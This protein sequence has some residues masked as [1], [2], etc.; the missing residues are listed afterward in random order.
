MEKLTDEEMEAKILTRIDREKPLN[1]TELKFLAEALRFKNE[2]VKNVIKSGI[3]PGA[4]SEASVILK[5]VAAHCLSMADTDFGNEIQKAVPGGA[6]E[7][8]VKGI[9][10]V[11]TAT[12]TAYSALITSIEK[13]AHLRET[14]FKPNADGVLN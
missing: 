6:N 1:K 11:I 14:L 10:S 7:I 3:R 4:H 9:Q 13:E 12:L 2:M 8:Q 5:L